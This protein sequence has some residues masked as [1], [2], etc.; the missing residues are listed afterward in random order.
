MNVFRD[1]THPKGRPAFTLIEL[2]VMIAIIAVLI[3]LL[4]PAVQKVREAAN[5]LSCQNNLK[6]I[7]LAIHNWENR[8]GTLPEDRVLTDIL[9]Y[10]D[11]GN[12]YHGDDVW[13]D[14]NLRPVK[15][16][17]C[18]S[19]P[20]GNFLMKYWSQGIGWYVPVAGVDNQEENGVIVTGTPASWWT[21]WIPN[22]Q[23]VG[24]LFFWQVGNFDSSGNFLSN[25][26]KGSK[27]S[28]VLDGLS[29]TVMIG[30]SSPS[31]DGQYEGWWNDGDYPGAA[32]T[33][34]M[35]LNDGGYDMNGNPIGNPCPPGPYYFG[36]GQVTNACDSNHFWSCHTGGAN[37]AFG[38]GSVP[39]LS[40]STSQI[41][42]KLATRA[43]GEVVDG[44]SY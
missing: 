20:R 22:P 36:P 4:L 15:L 28:D 13:D 30:E 29:N 31:P 12:L 44:S 16:Y 3:G 41:V 11:L 24:M 40:Y 32:E 1:R 23:Q 35:W 26:F 18:P 38:D 19:D 14:D 5:R 9:P 10:V 33:T 17:N 21:N 6:Q 7:G 43:C 37:F 25:T 27:I 34:M 39:F 2:L 8:R 42:V